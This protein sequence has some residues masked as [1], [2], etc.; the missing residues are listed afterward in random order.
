LSEKCKPQTSSSAPKLKRD[1]GLVRLTL[2]FNLVARVLGESS[3]V[4]DAL[5]SVSFSGEV[6]LVLTVGFVLPRLKM[7]GCVESEEAIYDYLNK[8]PSEFLTLNMRRNAL[9]LVSTFLWDSV[10]K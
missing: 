1:F 6:C 3:A 10:K 4:S 8:I 7:S 9:A 5:I 2:F